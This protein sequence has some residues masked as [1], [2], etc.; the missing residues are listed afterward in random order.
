MPTRLDIKL[1]RTI[2]LSQFLL[3]VNFGVKKI[4]K[5]GEINNFC[6]NHLFFIKY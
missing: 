3:K 1:C 6:Q 4:K 2:I 5:I